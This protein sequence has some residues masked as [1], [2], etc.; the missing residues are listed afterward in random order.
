MNTAAF[1][2]KQCKQELIN[3]IKSQYNDCPYHS[4]ITLNQQY[5]SEEK[6]TKIF[7]YMLTNIYHTVY[8]KRKPISNLEQFKHLAVIEYGKS[9]SNAHLH[10]LHKPFTSIYDENK[11]IDNAKDFIRLSNDQSSKKTTL[12]DKAIDL[13]NQIK[14]QYIAYDTNRIFTRAIKKVVKKADV[15]TI[16]IAD[17]YHFKNLCEYFTKELDDNHFLYFPEGYFLK[18]DKYFILQ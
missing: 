9:L 3:I 2:I 16:C 8:G 14:N 10:I 6:I 13:A 17:Q 1:I 5:F 11:L 15:K 7:Q 4:I 18:N 12:D